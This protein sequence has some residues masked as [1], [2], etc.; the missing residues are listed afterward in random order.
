MKNLFNNRSFCFDASL[1]LITF[2]LLVDTLSENSS[3]ISSLFL[4]PCARCYLNYLIYF[5][6][7]YPPFLVL[8]Y[9]SFNYLS[10]LFG[11]LDSRFYFI[12]RV[13]LLIYMNDYSLLIM[14][15]LLPVHHMHIFWFYHQWSI[16]IPFALLN[17][18]VYSTSFQHLS[19]RTLCSFLF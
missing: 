16:M 4:I 6:I 5:Y 14:S 8:Y 19:C 3:M 1:R 2:T 10:L 15:L 11:V 12:L 9:N 7:P 18:H 17:H 13:A